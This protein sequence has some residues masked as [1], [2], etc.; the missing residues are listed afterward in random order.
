[1]RFFSRF[2][3]A[4]SWLLATVSFP[5]FSQTDTAETVIQYKM[6]HGRPVEM[7]FSHGD[8]RVYLR[9]QLANYVSSGDSELTFLKKEVRRLTAEDGQITR[10]NNYTFVYKNGFLVWGPFVRMEREKSYECLLFV[11]GASIYSTTKRIIA[12]GDKVESEFWR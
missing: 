11:E 6:F 9:V 7:V 3:V 2:F 4:A 5:V 1:M 12:W 8:N 10:I